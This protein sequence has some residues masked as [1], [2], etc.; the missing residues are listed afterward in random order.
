VVLGVQWLEFTIINR[1][2][3]VK[4]KILIFTT[5]R[6][7]G[8]KAVKSGNYPIKTINYRDILPSVLSMQSI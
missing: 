3:E 8:G 5:L 4:I 2:F 1:G 7:Y 6:N